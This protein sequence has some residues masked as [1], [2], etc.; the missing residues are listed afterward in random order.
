[1][2][3]LGFVLLSLLVMLPVL[4]AQRQVALRGRREAALA[5]YRAQ[6][7]EVAEEGAR[8][9]LGAAE[10]REARL[11]IERRLLAADAA[12]EALPPAPRPWRS[13]RLALMV[14]LL[15]FL[16]LILYLQNGAP[17]LP[18]A[19][20]APRLQAMVQQRQEDEAML[21]LLR[22]KIARLDPTSEGARQG[23][24]LLGRLDADMGDA[25]GAAEAWRRALAIRF[26]PQLAKLQQA[27]AAIA[28]QTA[29]GR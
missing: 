21:A 14:P 15:P 6:L 17:L 12:A 2:I 26:D 3:W 28:Q 11:E 9:A 18:A 13:W 22:D 24:V 10:A 1:M 16:A 7:G 19:P 5:L 4:V 25:A 8:G 23:Y 27:A 20:L 29:E